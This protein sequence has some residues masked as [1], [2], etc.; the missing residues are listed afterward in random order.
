MYLVLIRVVDALMYLAIC[1]AMLV[2]SSNS[3]STGSIAVSR[4][5]G[6]FSLR[7]ARTSTSFGR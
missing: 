2:S 6:T 5:V 4:I 1:V 7:T 3:K